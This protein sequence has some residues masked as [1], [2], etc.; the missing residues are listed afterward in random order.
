MDPARSRLMQVKASVERVPLGH[1]G[2][3]LVLNFDIRKVSVDIP[4]LPPPAVLLIGSSADFC[5]Y[6]IRRFVLSNTRR[7]VQWCAF[8]ILLELLFLIL[9]VF[10]V[11]FTLLE[12]NFRVHL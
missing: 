2:I 9:I 6:T 7:G 4:L 12:D 10:I 3:V 8:S 1:L 11:L 5:L